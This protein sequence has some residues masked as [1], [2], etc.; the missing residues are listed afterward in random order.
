[1]VSMSQDGDA[2]H[3]DCARPEKEQDGRSVFGPER[4]LSCRELRE[5]RSFLKF[6]EE[7]STEQSECRR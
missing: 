2:H 5:E 4:D 7:L 3:F 1:M 6:R